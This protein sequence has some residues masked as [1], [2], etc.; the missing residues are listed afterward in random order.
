MFTEQM[1]VFCTP[2]MKTQVKALARNR[3]LSVP[4]LLRGFI[5]VGLAMEEEGE[6]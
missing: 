4:E 1:R 5:R 6:E 2:E 3:G